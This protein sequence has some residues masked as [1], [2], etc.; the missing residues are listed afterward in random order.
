MKRLLFSDIHFHTWPYGATP[1]HDG[2]NSRLAAQYAAAQEMVEY[3]NEHSIK[4]AYFLGDLFHLHGS[5]PTQALWCATNMFQALRANGTIV[6]SLFGN[7]D[8]SHRKGGRYSAISFI[9]HYND[10]IAIKKPNSPRFSKSSADNQEFAWWDD[11]R[12][13]G[14]S[15]TDDE[16]TLKRFFDEVANVQEKVMVLLHQGVAGVPLSSGF[17]L[18][19]RLTPAMIPDNAMA[20]TGHYHFYRRVSPNLTVVGNL[21]AL[22]WN[23]ID[24]TKGWVVF[25]DETGEIEQIPQTRAPEFRLAGRDNLECGTNFVRYGDAASIKEQ[26]EIRTTLGKNGALTVEFTGETEEEGAAKT[27]KAASG[28]ETTLAHLLQVYEEEMEPRRKEVGV[29][30][31]EERY[32]PPTF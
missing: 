10:D 31:R 14:L 6:R 23:D 19:E 3:A 18:D 12:V 29:E 13:M 15:Y 8:M 30:I 7:H 9:R 21:A 5:I 25:D 27:F 22:N 26:D 2:M 4:Y 16:D 11:L 32:A 20:F 17:L 24:Q 1:T 28:E